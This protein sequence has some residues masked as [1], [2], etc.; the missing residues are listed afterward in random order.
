MEML[1]SGNEAI[2]RGIYEFGGEF[3]SAYPGTPSTEILQ[4]IARYFKGDVYAEWAINEKCALENTVGASYGGARSVAAMKHVGVNVAADPLMTLSYTGVGAGLIL[5]SADDPSLHSSQ[6][7]QDNRCYGKFASI[8]VIEPSDSQEA[9]DFVKAGF[10]ISERFDTPVLFRITTRI[11]HSKGLVKIGERKTAGHPGFERDIAK[12]VMVPSNASKRHKIVID[13]L[14]E[15]AAFAEES[16]LNRIEWGGREVGIVTGSIAYQYARE[17][18][19]EASI[20]KLGLGYP[21]PMKKI[22]EFASQVKRLF[23]VEELEPF[24]EDQIRAA[25]IPVEGKRYFSNHLELNVTRV[26]NGFI[27][28]GVLD[29]DPVSIEQEQILPR[30]PVLC[31]G[32]PHRGMMVALKKLK[33]YTTGDIGCYTLGALPPLEQI[34]TCLCMGASIGHAFGIEKAGK[35]GKKAVALI[36][37]STFLHSG[38]TALASTVYNKG[39]TTTVIV[40]NRITAMTGGQDHPGT[41][42]TLMGEETH[43]I[44]LVKLCNAVGVEHVRVVDPYDLE[45]TTRVLEEEIARE[46]PSVVI[47]NRPCMLF[48][49]KITGAPYTVRLD[50]CTACGACFRVGC[51]AISGSKEKNE[52]GRSKAEIDPIL[53]TGCTICAQVCPAGAIVELKE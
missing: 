46:A 12:Y 32:C 51:P 21:L 17:A 53:C 11:S 20:L 16:P 7:E 3:A 9:K 8:P 50:L 33:V 14:E 26:R 10:E 24:Y 28:A 22:E 15:L 31:P 1:L 42:R 30:P 25:G 44:D 38:I 27:A 23:V 35:T 19:P 39:T 40:D 13:R 49:S 43:A 36:G 45:E 47:T 41:A 2:A 18:M 5:I 37:D 6:N 48:P 34:D 52:K 4:T 29:G